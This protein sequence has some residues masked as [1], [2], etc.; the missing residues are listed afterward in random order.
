[1]A[2][3]PEKPIEQPA[4]EQPAKPVA[5]PA[6][7]EP[8]LRHL[9]RIAATDLDGKK[10]ILFGL[11]RVKGVGV[12]T[13]HATCRV[14]GIDGYRKIGSLSDAEVK[15]LDEI[16]ADPGKA[17]F[18][19]WLFNRRKEPETG[20]DKHLIGTPL[21]VSIEGDIRNMKKIKAYKG[22]RHIFGAPVRGQRTRSHFR[23]NK[24]KVHLGVRLTSVTKKGGRV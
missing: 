7:A 9:V 17:G 1:M 16:L 14:A 12:M 4:R 15:K 19:Q 3:K 22:V 21:S 5:Q 13:A 6:T 10:S 24:G 23:K 18:P 11:V 2:D 20:A 8:E